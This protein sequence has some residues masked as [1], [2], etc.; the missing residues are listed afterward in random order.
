MKTE[1]RLVSALKNMM[2][3]TSLDKISVVELTKKCKINRQTFYYYYRDVYGLLTSVFLLEKIEGIEESKNT[4][5]LLSKIFDYYSKNN[6]FIDACIASSGKD[7]VGEFFFNNCYQN[8]L[9]MI[10]Q[11]RYGESLTIKERKDISRFYASAYAHS[12]IYYLMTSKTRTLNS[13]I[14][15]TIFAD[16]DLIITSIKK[17]IKSRVKK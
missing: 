8:I 9:R 5:E 14:K 17:I 1:Y 3:T 11:S 13:F 10:I 6:K 4:K 15:S 7:L 2:E 16:D 12:I